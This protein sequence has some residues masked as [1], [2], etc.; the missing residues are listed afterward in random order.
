LLTEAT[1]C[2]QAVQVFIDAAFV[3]LPIPSA[4]DFILLVGGLIALLQ[5]IHDVALM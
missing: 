5:P 3:L 4:I 2:Q 1:H